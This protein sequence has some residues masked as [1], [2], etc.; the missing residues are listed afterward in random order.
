MRSREKERERDSPL[1]LVL[2]MRLTPGLM[3]EEEAAVTVTVYCVPGLTFT[4]STCRQSETHQVTSQHLHNC[5]RCAW[6]RT[7]SVHYR[8]H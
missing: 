5:I 7:I 8:P 2:I 6:T 3:L 4:A 1:S